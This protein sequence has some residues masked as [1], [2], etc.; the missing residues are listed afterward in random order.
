A[1]LAVSLVGNGVFGVLRGVQR[2]DLEARA[3]FLAVPAGALCTCVGVLSGWGLWS[4]VAGSAMQLATQ[5][6]WQA[7][8][9]KRLLPWIK[10]RLTRINPFAIKAYL[11]LSGLALLSQVSD[12]IDSQW[13]KVVLS[14]FVGPAA[15]TSFQVSTSLVLQAKIVALLPLTPVLAG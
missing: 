6:I 13:D 9:S 12:V 8:A 10:P 3:Q 1:L 7:R 2:S 15:V 4:L 11:A 14:R 5:L